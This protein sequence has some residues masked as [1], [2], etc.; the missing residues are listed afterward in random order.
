MFTCLCAQINLLVLNLAQSIRYAS[1]LD[2]GVNTGQRSPTDAG[3]L[4]ESYRYDMVTLYYQ[5]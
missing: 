2:A 5:R 3:S 4:V 1:P